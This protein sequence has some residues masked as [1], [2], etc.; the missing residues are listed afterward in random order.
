[1]IH[2]PHQGLREGVD[3]YRRP[4]RV[5]IG[6]PAEIAFTG[7]LASERVHGGAKAGCRRRCDSFVDLKRQW[8]SLFPTDS[9]R[10][11]N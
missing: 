8:R 3:G 6:P 9:H 2:K 10:L 7:A 4:R 5:A 11:I 1:V